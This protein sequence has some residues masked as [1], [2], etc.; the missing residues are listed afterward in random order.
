MD[1][2][3]GADTAEAQ[4]MSAKREAKVVALIDSYVAKR[5][6]EKGA[7]GGKSAGAEGGVLS[8]TARTPEQ[9]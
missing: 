7:A 5:K 2:S 8:A 4:F 3:T 9:V 1:A 6:G